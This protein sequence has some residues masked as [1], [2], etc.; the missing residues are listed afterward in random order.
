M[1]TG[2]PYEKTTQKPAPSSTIV[3]TIAVL[4]HRRRKTGAAIAATVQIE[5]TGSRDRVLSLRKKSGNGSADSRASAHVKRDVA[6]NCATDW[7]ANDRRTQTRTAVVCPRGSEL[8]SRP[9]EGCSVG[10]CPTVLTVYDEQCVV[11][12]AFIS[13]SDAL[14]TY[15]EQHADRLQYRQA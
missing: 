1:A 6:I 5:R 11:S 7:N 8:A 2:N 13:V 12:N 9:I 3:A 14:T 4:T 10:S 15:S